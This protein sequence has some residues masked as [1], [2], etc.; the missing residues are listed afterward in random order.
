MNIHK[1]TW[2][3]DYIYT[4]EKISEWQYKMKWSNLSYNK[5]NKS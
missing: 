5:V 2:A 1:I 4:K 3:Y